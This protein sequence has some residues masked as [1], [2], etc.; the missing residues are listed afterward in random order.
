[1]DHVRRRLSLSS[2]KVSNM[3]LDGAMG[4]LYQYK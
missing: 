4:I 3:R 1:M 2:N